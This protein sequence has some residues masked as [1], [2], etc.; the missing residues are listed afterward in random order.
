MKNINKGLKYHWNYENIL[1]NECPDV[2]SGLMAKFE[3]FSEADEG[4]ILKGFSTSN[5]GTFSSDSA[6]LDGEGITVNIWT[7]FDANGIYDKWFYKNAVSENA[8]SEPS[9]I[10]IRPDLG[11]NSIYYSIKSE[12]GDLNE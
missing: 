8:D 10:N 4:K 1:G 5:L 12:E 2:H 11:F 6:I 7:K 3:D 9:Y